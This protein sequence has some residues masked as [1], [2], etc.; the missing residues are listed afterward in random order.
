MLLEG[1][2]DIRVARMAKVVR[3]YNEF[4]ESRRTANGSGDYA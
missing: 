3:R 2:Y 4:D 1:V